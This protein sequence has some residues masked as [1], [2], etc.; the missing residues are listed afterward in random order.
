MYSQA[1]Y[2]AVRPT[3]SHSRG[4]QIPN[5][6]YVHTN[7][8]SETATK[9]TTSH[10]E[11]MIFLPAAASTSAR[12]AVLWSFGGDVADDDHHRSRKDRSQRSQP[13]GVNAQERNEIGT[14]HRAMCLPIFG[15]RK[16]FD[17]I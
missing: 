10:G 11:M 15:A 4:S 7:G 13:N 16:L 14:D 9:T 3:T 5:S 1:P 6:K 17:I 8:E 2:S 12:L